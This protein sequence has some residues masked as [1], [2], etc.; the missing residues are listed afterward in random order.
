M[1]VKSI[2]FLMQKKQKPI[3]NASE[4]LHRRNEGNVKTQ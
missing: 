2:E 3:K 1:T 4:S